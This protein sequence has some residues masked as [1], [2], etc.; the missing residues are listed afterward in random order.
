MSSCGMKRVEREYI[1]GKVAEFERAGG[2][3]ERVGVEATGMRGVSVQKKRLVAR[4]RKLS[5][6]DVE[7]IMGL[8]REGRLS[9]IAIGELYGVSGSCVSDIVNGKSYTDFTGG[10]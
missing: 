10:G 4:N 3:V 7:G 2:V 5:R 1:A 9:R 8:V 6:E